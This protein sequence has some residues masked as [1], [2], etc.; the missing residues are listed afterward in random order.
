VS[1]PYFSVLPFY[2]TDA[3][4]GSSGEVPA[5]ETRAR[6]GCR[7]N[8]VFGELSCPSRET[9]AEPDAVNDIYTPSLVFSLR[10]AMHIRFCFWYKMKYGV[11]C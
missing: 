9:K 2:R 1:A 4:T 5:I 11:S 7:S 10:L 3:S 8:G 6:R